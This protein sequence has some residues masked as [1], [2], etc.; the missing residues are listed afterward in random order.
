MGV[1]LRVLLGY[2]GARN[3]LGLRIGLLLFVSQRHYSVLLG[4][5]WDSPGSYGVLH[6]WAALLLLRF[7]VPDADL[8]TRDAELPGRSSVL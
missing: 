2:Y 6:T 3:G 8:S 7:R 4:W 5:S 1:Y